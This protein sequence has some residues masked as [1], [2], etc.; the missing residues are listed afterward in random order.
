MPVVDMQD[1]PLDEAQKWRRFALKADVQD[2]VG[3][4][5]CHNCLDIIRALGQRQP[6]GHHLSAVGDVGGDAGAPGV[7]DVSAIK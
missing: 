1:I 3:Q 5:E 7:D 2:R 4:A 6:V